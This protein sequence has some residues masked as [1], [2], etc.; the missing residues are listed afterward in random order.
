MQ[1]IAVTKHKPKDNIVM[2]AKRIA[3]LLIDKGF[4]YV[5][6]E[7]E[8][9]V[10]PGD[11]NAESECSVCY[12]NGNISCRNCD[13]T[14]TTW[15]TCSRCNGRGF[16][17]NGE[18]KPL[19]CPYCDNGQRETSCP[20]CS[21][22]HIG[23]SECNGM[24][25][26]DND[27]WHE[28]YHDAFWE[29]FTDKL[30]EILRLTE[31]AHIYYDGSV[32]TEVTMTLR[33]D[34]LEKLPEI[35]RAFTET[36]REFGECDTGNAGLHI[37]LLPCSRYPVKEKLDIEKISNFRKQV[38][39]LLLGLVCL[40]S[41]DDRTRAFEFRDLVVSRDRKYS[42]V[43]T[44]YDT[45]IEFRLFD[46]CLDRPSYII[47]YMELIGKTLRYYS[48]S[49]KRFLKLKDTITLKRSNEILSKSYR[50]CYR[51]LDDVFRTEESIGRLFQEL[52]YLIKVKFRFWLNC[53]YTF[54]TLGTIT[55]GELFS[56]LVSEL[57]V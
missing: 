52:S 55:K 15:T 24:G 28:D 53:I 13:G 2:R 3:N 33:A 10:R 19:A 30:G 27:D 38:S 7:L 46:A 50:G 4:P 6:V 48:N 21:D 1:T 31:H 45:C 44:H 43:Y 17:D 8:A 47:R 56:K 37:T 32:D 26:F 20:D 22:G 34:Y 11:Y 9:N 18:D 54:Y 57:K 42:A 41:P 36:C 16:I 40:G 5:K 51:K 35:V 23:C 49:P 29:I 14:G 25:Y 39:K 12:G